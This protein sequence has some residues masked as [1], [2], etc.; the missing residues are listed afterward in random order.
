MGCHVTGIDHLVIRV[1]DLD[2]AREVYGRLGFKLTPPGRHTGLGTANHTAVFSDRTYLEFLAVERSDPEVPFAHLADAVEGPGAL[3]LR[4][5]DAR[6]YGHR[7]SELGLRP[8]APVSFDRP[9]EMPDG[10]LEARFTAL[11]LPAEM[12]PGIAGF[13]YEQHTPDLVWLPDYLEHENGVIGL[14]AVMIAAP[15]PE[16]AIG[17]WARTFGTP[18]EAIAEGA[19]AATA[20]SARIVVARPAFLNWIWTGDPALEVDRPKLVGVAL[21]VDDLYRAQRALQKSRIPV[22]HSNGALRVVSRHALDTGLMFSVDFD[23]RSLLP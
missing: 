11:P 10:D 13:A 8:G 1:G 14:S 18:I 17:P 12:T 2:R 6:A 20:G 9:V 23:P 21:R 3:A 4:A 15:E 19:F 22:I 7:L 16:E 5:S